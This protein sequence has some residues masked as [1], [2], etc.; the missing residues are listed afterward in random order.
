[1]F[2][3]HSCLAPLK[4][5]RAPL[6]HRNQTGLW[7]LKNK[8]LFSLDESTIFKRPHICVIYYM[9]LNFY[10]SWEH[11]FNASSLIIMLAAYIDFD[12]LCLYLIFW[13]MLCLS[14]ALNKCADR[15]SAFVLNAFMAPLS[16]NRTCRWLCL[17]LF[18]ILGSRLQICL[19]WVVQSVF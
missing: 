15:C 19:F 12:C 4:I 7:T 11:M 8:F 6:S 2:I 10:W 9:F 16:S 17:C 13:H 5:N 1:M 3:K 14:R 18:R